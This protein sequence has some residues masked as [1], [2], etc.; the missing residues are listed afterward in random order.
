MFLMFFVCV[1]FVSFLSKSAKIEIFVVNSSIQLPFLFPV[2]LY[3]GGSQ[4]F[5]RVKSRKYCN[6]SGQSTKRGGGKG[7]ST[8][9]KRNFYIYFLF[10]FSFVTVEKLNIF[11]LRRH[12]V[13][14]ISISISPKIVEKKKNVKI[15]FPAISR[16]KKK[17]SFVH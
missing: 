15:R 11:C 4:K 7:L 5:I 8:Y 2:K 16:R 14:C 3:R 9:K 1:F 12:S 6:L 10:N 17:K 13:L